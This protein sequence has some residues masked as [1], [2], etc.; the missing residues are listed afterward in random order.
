MATPTFQYFTFSQRFG[1]TYR[2][3]RCSFS[4]VIFDLLGITMAQYTGIMWR[5]QRRVGDKWYERP[6]ICQAFSLKKVHISKNVYHSPLKIDSSPLWNVKFFHFLKLGLS[7]GLLQKLQ[8]MHYYK[9]LN[10][11]NMEKLPL[12]SAHAA[13]LIERIYALP[14]ELLLLEA[15][16]AAANFRNWVEEHFL[17]EPSQV[18]F[19]AA[20][21]DRM[22]A[23]V[24]TQLRIFLTQRW[25]IVFLKEEDPKDDKPR[26][27]VFE[28]KQRL[29]SNCGDPQGYQSAAELQLSITYPLLM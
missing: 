16:G 13:V 18:T 24:G 1:L 10:L 2:L 20:L 29:Q 11:K 3:E 28:S 8:P 5:L 14:D 7:L 25:P 23:E 12:D 17:L 4:A 27:K 6:Q 26:G 22:V 21:D 15:A 19:L 9:N